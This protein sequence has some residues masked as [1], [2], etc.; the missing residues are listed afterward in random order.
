VVVTQVDGEFS[1]WLLA[2]QRPGA[3][4]QP[5][6]ALVRYHRDVGMQHEHW[7]TQA[8]VRPRRGDG[9]FGYRP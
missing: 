1:G 7:V 6:R 2:S 4:G 8:E 9:H 3:A 5:W